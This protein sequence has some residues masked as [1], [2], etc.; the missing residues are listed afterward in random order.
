MGQ[1]KRRISGQGGVKEGKR[2]GRRIRG[3]EEED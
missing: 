2:K 3:G 1:K